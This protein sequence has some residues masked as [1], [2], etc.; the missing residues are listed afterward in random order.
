MVT[1]TRRLRVG[2]LAYGLDRPP[3]GIG[4]Y[5]IEIAKAITAHHPEIDLVLVTPFANA[6]PALP[7]LARIRLRGT[8]LL[9]A[10]MAFGPMQLSMAVRRHHLDV[11]HDPVGIAPFWFP[12][13]PPTVGRV[14]TIHDMVPFV[15]PETHARMTNVLYLRYLPKA[16]RRADCII[17]DSD[18]SRRDIA[19][20][21]PVD[22]NRIARIYCGIGAQFRPQPPDVV[23]EAGQR[24]GIQTP[25]ILAV[26]A[27]EARKNM[28][29]VLDAYAVI[30]RR[31]LPHHLVLV[32]P[33]AWK[34]QGIFQRI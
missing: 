1:E 5:A 13:W 31:G 9:P 25:Y 29:A 11:I 24:L 34:S 20:F 10:L 19:R 7:G 26:G 28:E 18:S 2:L 4:R 6:I 3:T 21:F 17:T 23:A 8:R 22:P 14:V 33:R 15:H 16:I 30:R 12:R 32:G 27:L